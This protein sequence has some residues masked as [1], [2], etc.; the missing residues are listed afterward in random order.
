MLCGWASAADSSQLTGLFS[1]KIKIKRER[2]EKK[3]FTL[4][5]STF[6]KAF[7]LSELQNP[8]DRHL[9]LLKSFI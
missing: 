3:K 6:A 2:K 4:P 5:S 9:Q 1:S 8:V 7:F